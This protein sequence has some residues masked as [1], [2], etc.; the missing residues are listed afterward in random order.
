MIGASH[1]Q[2]R[3]LVGVVR[4]VCGPQL[5]G[6]ANLPLTQHPLSRMPGNI[7]NS[8]FERDTVT[9]PNKNPITY[10]NTMK[11]VRTGPPNGVC[12]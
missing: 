9:S 7:C 3:Q 2:V 8:C 6:R 4:L 10:H 11:R 12:V 1:A 5:F